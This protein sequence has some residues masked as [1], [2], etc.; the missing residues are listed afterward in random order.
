M[1]SHTPSRRGHPNDSAAR[2]AAKTLVEDAYFALRQDIVEGKHQP[3]SRLRVEHLKDDYQVGAGTL[4]EALS[5]LVSD[6]LVVAEGQRGFTVASMSLEDLADIT[7][8]RVLLETEA[9]CRSLRLGDNVWEGDL[10]AAFHRLSK[11]ETEMRRTGPTVREWEAL[12]AN[13]HAALIAACDSQWIKYMLGILYRQSERYRRYLI[14]SRGLRRDVHA[15]H[16][17]IFE[18]AI[19]R[20]EKRAADALERHVRLT[21]DMVRLRPPGSIPTNGGGKPIA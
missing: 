21:Y 3:G 16:S 9:L 1:N 11:I 4:R 10:V 7:N 12:N 20:N 6:A 2:A 18:A 15:E 5:R 17:E 19:R 14:A 13:F 8:T